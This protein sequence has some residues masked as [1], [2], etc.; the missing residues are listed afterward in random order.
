[1]WLMFGA[2]VAGI[3]VALA[4]PGRFELPDWAFGAAQAVTGVALGAYLQSSSLTAVAD[5]WLAVALVSAG[6]LGACIAAGVVL[7]RTTEVDEATATLGMVAGGA[8]GIVAMAPDLGG[9]ER[10]VAFMQYARVLIIVVLTPILAALAFPG[11]H[12]AGGG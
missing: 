10:L 5:S 9:D 7:A 12:A 6:T 4:R 8:S 1:M 3:L 11:H 2:L